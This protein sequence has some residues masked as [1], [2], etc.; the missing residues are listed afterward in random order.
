MKNSKQVLM[1]ILAM[2]GF[3]TL[4][5]SQ[6][7]LVTK[8]NTFIVC[9]VVK[10]GEFDV[11]YKKNNT[12]ASPI[13][14]MPVDKLREIR[15]EDG[16]TEKFVADEMD[17]N[18]EKDILHKRSAVKFS[19]FS[20]MFSH[21]SFSYEKCLKVGTN[22][23][24]TVGIISDNLD[25]VE[26]KFQNPKQD[27]IGITLGAGVKF[28]LGQEFYVKGIKYAHPLKGRYIK[29]EIIH[30]RYIYNDVE[31]TI[32][33]N[34]NGYYGPTTFTN[35]KYDLKVRSTAFMINYGR[36]FILGNV[37]TF[38][39]QVGVGYS[40]TNTV[41]SNIRTTQ[42]DQYAYGMGVGINNFSHVQAPSPLSWSGNIT[43]G[44]LFDKKSNKKNSPLN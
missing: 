1:T 5:F 38:G 19:F 3:S 8:Q 14:T 28:L 16:T 21:L 23:E 25:V 11:E 27:L 10:I 39:Y 33:N 40:F 26:R 30:T 24:G 29:P 43:L 31:R 9:K 13:Y 36:Q 2:L 41:K 15:L 12:P 6:D 42:S 4:T 37:M 18:K 7:T 32:N 20:P 35:E 22:L 34:Y 44:F 17:A